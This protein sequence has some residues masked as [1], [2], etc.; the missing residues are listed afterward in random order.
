MRRRFTK[1]EQYF[2]KYLKISRRIDQIREDS[3]SWEPVEIPYRQG[4][5]FQYVIDEEEARRR[6]TEKQLA[7]FRDVLSRVRYIVTHREK[8]PIWTGSDD[9]FL[10]Y[11]KVRELPTET[12]D[13]YF[14]SVKSNRWGRTFTDYKL[15]ARWKKC[16]RIKR[17]PRYIYWRKALDT[18]LLK[19]YA[20][21][22]KIAEDPRYYTSSSKYRRFWDT[23]EEEAAYKYKKQAGIVEEDEITI[24]AISS[25]LKIC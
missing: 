12:R 19:E 15:K 4:Y 8:N 1:Q 7:S 10:W 3:F 25:A 23:Q 9:W 13:T 14:Y 5:Y 11:H 17:S 21:L 6:L 18:K 24:D 20:F 16:L 22:C 2:K